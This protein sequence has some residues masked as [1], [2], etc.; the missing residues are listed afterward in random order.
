M[1]SKPK[2][3]RLR[4]LTLEDMGEAKLALHFFD[5]GYGFCVAKTGCTYS[6]FPRWGT[7]ADDCTM[8]YVQLEDGTQVGM[9]LFYASTA[10]AEA[11]IALIAAL[12]KWRAAV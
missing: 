11:Y 9:P 10:Q 1:Q 8:M 5:N 3:L 6:V 4:D 7:C 12:P 2:Q